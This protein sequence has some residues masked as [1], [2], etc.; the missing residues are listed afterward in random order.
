MRLAVHW[1][2]LLTRLGVE[3]SA[4]AT[5]NSQYPVTMYEWRAD[6]PSDW[7]IVG[8]NQY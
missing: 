4:S 1:L 7:S 2:R 5:C 8:Q 3:F 6:Y